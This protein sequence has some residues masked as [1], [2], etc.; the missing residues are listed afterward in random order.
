MET[1]ACP[2]TK[3]SLNNEMIPQATWTQNITMIEEN[4]D[5]GQ[6]NTL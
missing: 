3:R 5:V 2:K 4:P 1:A 6:E